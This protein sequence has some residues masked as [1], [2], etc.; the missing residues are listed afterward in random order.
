[1]ANPKPITLTQVDEADYEGYTPQPFVLV[2]DVPAGDPVTLTAV[3]ESFEDLPAAR[4]YLD[5]LVG[6]LKSSP[7]FN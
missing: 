3:P 1:M 5:I 2:G 4:T 7:Y 6:E